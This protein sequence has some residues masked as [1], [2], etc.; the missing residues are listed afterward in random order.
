MLKRNQIDTLPFVSKQDNR[1]LLWVVNPT[2]QYPA[3]C[4]TGRAYAIELIDYMRTHDG[5]SLLVNIVQAMAAT[6]Q[7]FSG[8][9]I[10]F[11]TTISECAVR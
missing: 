2:G 5:A 4:A 6:G 10:G 1:V 3:D 9:E 11:I 8:I 7:P